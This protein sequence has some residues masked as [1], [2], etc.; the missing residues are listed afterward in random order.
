MLQT[1]TAEILH[2]EANMALALGFCAFTCVYCAYM[3][4]V[5]VF[6]QSGVLAV[7]KCHVAC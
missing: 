6:I 7:T 3:G 2:T 5:M 4:A 1:Q